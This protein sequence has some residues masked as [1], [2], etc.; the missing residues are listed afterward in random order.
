MKTAR[1]LAG[2]ILRSRLTACVNLV[3][4]LE[5]H[6]WWQSRLERS[7]EVLLVIKTTRRRLT[8]LENAVKRDHPYD[9]PEIIAWPLGSGNKRYLDWVKASVATKPRRA[10]R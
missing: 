4:G 2:N 10:A 8:A 9:T 1:L 7:R 6:Y 5:S 3:P